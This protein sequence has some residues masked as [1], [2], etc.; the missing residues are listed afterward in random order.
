[1]LLIQITSAFDIYVKH[2]VDSLK[3][4]CNG[5]SKI[6]LNDMKLELEGNSLGFYLEMGKK[7]MASNYCGCG[8]GKD[9][10]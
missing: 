3:H 6:E 5:I 10:Y 7:Q 8:F 2:K 4:V 9:Y 1:M